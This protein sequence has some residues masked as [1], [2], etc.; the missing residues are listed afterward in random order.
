[1]DI[2]ITGW[3]E[4]DAKLRALSGPTV[5]RIAKPALQAG[6]AVLE[7]AAKTHANTIPG[8]MGAQIARAI[9]QR[10]IR[11]LRDGGFSV[12]VAVDPKGQYESEFV[13][14]TQA[15]ARQYIPAAIEYGHAA[16]YDARGPKIVAAIPYM[17]PAYD[18]EKGHV[19]QV[20]DE[21]FRAGIE[22]EVRG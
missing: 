13:H 8:V 4:L 9:G 7:I 12:A 14:V 21:Q 18:Q 17:R 16:P 10:R 22:K 5:Q 2:Q 11:Q 1:M 19:Q 15:G 6:A 3:R 20:V